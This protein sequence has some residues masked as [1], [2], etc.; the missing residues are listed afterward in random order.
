MDRDALTG[1]GADG[2]ASGATARTPI[3]AAEGLLAIEPVLVAP[4]DHLDAVIRRASAAPS[5]RVLGVVDGSG[6]LVGVVTSHDLVASIVGRLAPAALL[7]EV[8]DVEGVHVFERF[9]EATVAGDLMHPP[10][11]LRETATM[12]EAFRL[13]HE[14]DLSGVYVV[15]TAGRPIGYVDG[16]ELAAAVVGPG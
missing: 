12:A 15:D 5:T 8:R 10:A 6:V 1:S 11:V 16:L 9:V 4:G 14:Q 2:R 13:M 7:T 3:S